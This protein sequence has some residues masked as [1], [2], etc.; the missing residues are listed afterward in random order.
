[1]SLFTSLR[2]ICYGV[3]FTIFG[4]VSTTVLGLFVLRFDTEDRF[5]IYLIFIAFAVS[6]FFSVFLTTHRLVF[7]VVEMRPYFQLDFIIIPAAKNLL[8]KRLP[9][10]LKWTV[11]IAVLCGIV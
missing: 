7:P 10:I 4:A 11:I 1:M 6:T 5:F 3:L 9:K 2:T 8:E